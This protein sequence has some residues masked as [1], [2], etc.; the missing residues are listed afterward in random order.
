MHVEGPGKGRPP[1]KGAPNKRLP[2]VSG[3]W[4]RG[5]GENKEDG[6]RVEKY[7]ELSQREENLFKMFPSVPHKETSV[8]ET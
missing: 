6:L 5:S 3:P 7:W 4:G 2:Q 1:V 8:G